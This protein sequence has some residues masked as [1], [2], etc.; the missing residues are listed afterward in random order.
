MLFCFP[1]APRVGINFHPI[2]E[3]RHDQNLINW[4]GSGEFPPR[5][6]FI[7]RRLPLR[8][9]YSQLFQPFPQH[10]QH[11]NHKSVWWVAEGKGRCEGNSL[12]VCI[13]ITDAS[14]IWLKT[15]WNDIVIGEEHPAGIAGRL[16]SYPYILRFSMPPTHSPELPT[17]V[18]HTKGMCRVYCLYVQNVCVWRA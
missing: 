9:L 10:S 2:A 15:I 6:Q 5:R 12:L 11:V 18:S 8:Q 3:P 17:C 1:S 14:H 13:Q 16:F 4:P 7:F